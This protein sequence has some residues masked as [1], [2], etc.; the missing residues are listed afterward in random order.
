SRADPTLLIDFEMAAKGNGDLPAPDLWTIEE[1]CQPS[2]NCRGG[3]F[4]KRRPGECYDLIE[5]ITPH[6][7]DWD[8]SAQ[9]SESS[10]SITSSSDTEITTLKA[11]MAK[12][13]KNLMRVLQVNQQVK[14]VTPNCET[15]GGPHSFNDCPATV[16]QTH[17]VYAAGAYQSNSY[18]PQGNR[19]LLSYRLDNYLGPLGNT[20]TNP[21]EDLKVITTR[22][23]TVYQGPMIPTS[24]SSFSSPPT[25]S[26]IL[27]SEPIVAPIIKPVV[28]PVSASKP[29]QRPLIPYPSRLHDQKPRDKA[30][31]QREEFFQIFKDLNF[32]ISFAGALILMP[33][34]GPTIKTL[35]TNKDKLSELA[36]TPLN[37]YCSTANLGASINLMPL[38]VW[39][40]LSLP[41]LSPMCMTLELADHSI[42]HPVGVAEDVFVK[43]GTFHFPA[44]FVVVDFDADPRV[45]LI[46]ERSFLKTGRALIDV[47]EGELTLRVGKEAITFNLD[48]T[49]RYSANY[50][51]MTAK[52]I[53]VI[54]MACEEYS[55]EV[56]GFSDVI[57]SG[58]PTPYYDPIVSTTSPTLTPFGNSDFLLE[59]VDACLALED[60]AT[61]PEVD[62]S[63][64]DTE[65]DILLLEAFL[66][67]DSSL[68]PPNQG[69]YLPQVRKELK[70]YEAKTGVKKLPIIIAKD[71]SVE[72]KI[73]LITVLK[74]HKRAI[75]WKLSDIKDIDPEFCTQKIL[76]EE[77]F[78]LAI[79]HQRRVNPKIHD[80]IKNEVLKLLDAGL[81]YPISDSPWV[82][83]IH[84]VLKKGGFTVIENEENKLIPTRLVMGSRVCIDYRKLKEATCKD[85]FPLPLMDQMLERLVGNEYYCFLDGFSEKMLKLYEDTNLCL[86][87]EKSHFMV[88][89]GIVLGHKI[90]KNGIEVDKAKVDVI[91]KLPHPTTVLLLQ[92]FTFKVIDTKGAENLAADHLSRLENPH[93]NVL[94]HKEINESFPLE[95]LNLVSFRGNSSTPWFTDFANYHARNFVVNGMSPRTLEENFYE[96]MQMNQFAGAVSAIPEIVHRYMDQRMN[97][98]V[99]VAIQLQSD[100]LR[101]EA[102][103]ENDEFLK[104]IDENMQ[105]IIKEKVKEQV[106]VQVSKILPR[107]EQTMNEQLESKVLT[108][109]SHSSKTSYAVAADLFKMELKKIII[110]ETEGNKFIQRSDEQRNLYKALIEAYESYKII[111]DTYGESV[112]LKRCRDGDVD[113][114]EEPSAGPDRGSKR[115]REGKEPES[116]SAPT[117]TATRSAGRSTQGTKSRQA[118]ASESAT[119]EEPM[120]TTFQMEEPSH[121]EF[122]TGA[123]D[124]PIVQSSPHPEWFSQQQKPPTSDRDWN[125]TLP[126][127]HESIQLWISELAKQSDSRSSFNELMDI[128]MDFS[129][130]LIN[131][132]KV[133]TLTPKL[134]A[135]PTYELLKGSSKSL[136]ELEYHLE[137]VYKATIDQ[138]DWVNP[139][140]QQYPHNL[141]KPLPLIP[142][143]RGHCVIPFEHFINNDLE[144][145]CGGASSRK[146]T[147][148]VTKT[149]AAKYGHIKWIEDL[150]PRIMWIEEVIGYDKHSLWGVSHWRRKR[151]QFYS[152]AVNQESARDVYSKRRIIA[153][154]ELK[155]VKWHN[156]KHL[157]WITKHRD[158]EACGRPSTGCQ[159]LPEEAQ[160]NEAG[161]NKDKKNRLIRIDELHK[162]SDGTLTDVHTALD[163][164]LKG[165]QMQYLPQ[166]IWRKSDKDRAAAMIQAIDKRLKTRRI[167]RS[168]ERFVGGRLYEGDFRMLQRTI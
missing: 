66:N 141:L 58:N 110:E 100:K 88:K 2:L 86:N 44:D 135:S 162:F 87:Y 83:P 30:N 91:A 3:T 80:V 13:N 82:S 21:K 136:V 160:P 4:M 142:N 42:S 81:I 96:F 15:C 23:G 138:L 29:N 31:D 70:I 24:S 55:Q 9:W 99:Q 167:M 47:F 122:D 164:R 108:R 79:Q 75:A 140:G 132:F 156:Y 151:Q 121:P 106:K 150:V 102:Q 95:T 161:Y 85:H 129:N 90:S 69:N 124:R 125:T 71:L 109:S 127:T 115:R 147:T 120:Q 92:E 49:S 68:P 159:K 62:Q 76:M 18:Q 145:L 50:N 134:I 168:L 116:A 37:K 105:K 146:Y 20:I 54:D 148:S 52:Q 133:D 60:D 19:N 117:K 155:I 144:Y 16:G 166:S 103:K 114:D 113:K 57:A 53:N 84:Y 128:P 101:E 25:E 56:L 104:T 123:E 152:F 77:D 67:D 107:I 17:N 98:A 111:L 11:E 5:N 78:E 130:F 165:I 6:H 153:V 22:S 61:S 28:A 12:I 112:T 131:R 10:S 26:P 72:E 32:N 39:N 14:A 149:K 89:R 154:T 73:A 74:S 59:E 36:K 38:S 157:D 51:D 46:L 33:K 163:D 27:N 119:G 126:A 48:Q 40:K 139:E 45:P 8:T 137:E 1:L 7:K 41:N 34:F 158:P 64:V 143:N 94:D 93:Q 118:S 43:V 63:Y 65:G 35:L 97:E